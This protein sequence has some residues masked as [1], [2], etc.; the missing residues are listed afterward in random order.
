LTTIVT[1]TRGIIGYSSTRGLQK[2]WT[3]IPTG[4]TSRDYCK[5]ARSSP[6]LLPKIVTRLGT[7]KYLEIQTG[8][9]LMRVV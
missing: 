1:E 9:P 7:R 6:T 2:I 3:L 5:V 4:L 8:E